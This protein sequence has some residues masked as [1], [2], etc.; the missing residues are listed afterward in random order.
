MTLAACGGPAQGHR[1]ELRYPVR[2]TL[3]TVR[4]GLGPMAAHASLFDSF[5]S[6]QIVL[7]PLPSVKCSRLILAPRRWAR[8]NGAATARSPRSASRA[9]PPIIIGST[10]DPTSGQRGPFGT[11]NN[12]RPLSGGTLPRWRP[13]PGSSGKQPCHRFAASIRDGCRAVAGHLVLGDRPRLRSGCGRAGSGQRKPQIPWPDRPGQAAS[14]M[15]RR[16]SRGLRPGP[17]WKGGMVG[18]NGFEP[19]TSSM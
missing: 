19:L 9:R 1:A 7:I 18:D 15:L 11:P 16:A 10:I 5:G 6:R 12:T 4:R 14:R 13:G 3:R 8:T 17:L 2:I